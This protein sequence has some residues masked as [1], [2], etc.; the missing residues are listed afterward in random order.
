MTGK[1]IKEIRKSWGFSQQKLA[2][3]ICHGA[4]STLTDWEDG[5]TKIPRHVKCLY[6]LMIRYKG[7]IDHL[8]E[9]LESIDYQWV[10]CST[11]YE[12]YNLPEDQENCPICGN[13]IEI[14]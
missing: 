5:K 3:I 10:Y 11:C 7:S 8:Q 9:Q 14:L 4:R 2:D 1:Q 13:S 6:L 12:E